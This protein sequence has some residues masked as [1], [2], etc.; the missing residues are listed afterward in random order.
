MKTPSFSVVI[1]V[2]AALLGGCAT[3]GQSAQQLAANFIHRQNVTPTT[4]ESF[5][6]KNPERIA[7]YKSQQKPLTPYRIIGIASVSK[8][9]LI[10]ME[11]EEP[12][13]HEMMRRL[14]ASIG[15]DGLIDIRNENDSLQANIIQF[16][17]ILI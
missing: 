16:Q 11:R 3:K 1:I 8:R 9:N 2:I 15:G 5:P 14:A 13:M 4:Q 17:K 7:L 10:G 6:A 12:T